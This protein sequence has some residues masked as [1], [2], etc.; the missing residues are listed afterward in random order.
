V[1]A[2]VIAMDAAR[3][4][5]MRLL[6]ARPPKPRPVR[7]APVWEVWRGMQRWRVYEDSRRALRWA[8]L[9]SEARMRAKRPPGIR[10]YAVWHTDLDPEGL[11][12]I[13][14]WWEPRADRHLATG[15]CPFCGGLEGVDCVC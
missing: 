15:R 14:V 2:V 8:R 3:R 11:V 10:V 4:R 6:L 13:L 5:L 1:P 9:A 12:R 7:E